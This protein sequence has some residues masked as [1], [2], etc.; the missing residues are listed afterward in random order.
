MCQKV[1][2]MFEVD[3]A[4]L[5][6][7]NESILAMLACQMEAILQVEVGS[8]HSAKSVSIKDRHSFC[9][10]AAT[11]RDS[12]NMISSFNCSCEWLHHLLRR[13]RSDMKWLMSSQ[14]GGGM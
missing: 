9:K 2:F 5:M 1:I 3:R 6:G 13:S 10:C 4:V 14:N 8:C 12:S 7:Q 11:N